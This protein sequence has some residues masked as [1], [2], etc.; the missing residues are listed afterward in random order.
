METDKNEPVRSS[1]SMFE[2]TESIALLLGKEF[3]L[4]RS[5]SSVR[6]VKDLLDVLAASGGEKMA[7]PGVP[8]TIF[9]EGFEI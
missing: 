5:V 8:K 4:R 3:D 7:L 1:D 9:L 2:D 6:K